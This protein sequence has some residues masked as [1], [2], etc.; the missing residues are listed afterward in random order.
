MD[1]K[2]LRQKILD[3]AIHGKLVPQDPNDEP[4]SVLLE[5]IKAEKERLI[6]EGKIKGSKKSAK[7]SD[8][9]HYPYLLPKGWE[10]CKLEDIAYVASGSTP[11]KESF[12]SNG[13]PYIK[14]YNLRNQKIDFDFKPQYIKTETHNGKLQRSRTEVGD[15]IMNIVGPPLGKL[16]IIPPSLPQ[17]NFNQAAVL[18]RPLLHKAILTKYLFYYLSEMSEINSISTKG[19]AGQVNISLTQSQNMRVPLPPLSEQKRIIAELEYCFDLISTIEQSQS[20]LQDTIKQAKSKILDLAIHGKLVPQDPNDEPAS[21][22]LK[23][24]NPKAEITCDNGHYPV[25]WIDVILGDIFYHNTGKALNSSNKEGVLRNYLTTSNVYWNQFDLSLV[26]QMP[27]RDNELEKCTVQKGD[28]L[29]CEGGDVGRSAIWNFD[30]NICIQNHIHRLRPKGD[31][32][33]SFYYYVLRFLKEHNR[34][35]GKGIGLL[36]LSSNEL[37]KIGMPLPPRKEQDRIVLKIEELFSVLDNIENALE[38]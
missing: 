7:A 12:V 13:I 30:Y 2:K 4:A 1:T 17:A 38:A 25:G 31:L 27:F 19:S 23:R 20:D 26:K 15:L 6:K 34:I 35:G 36:G 24:I 9:P 22:L 8:M 33:V 5:H 18:I 11:S 28:L 32:N 16:A 3:L 29:V 10:W 21:E 37:H 14:M